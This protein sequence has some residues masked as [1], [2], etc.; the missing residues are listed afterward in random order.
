M[1]EKRAYFTAAVTGLLLAPVFAVGPT[2]RPDAT[3]KGSTLSG[4]HVLGQADWRAQNGELTGTTKPGG[5]GGWLVQDRSYQ[6]VA[7][8]SSFRCTGECKTGVLLRA[9]K[10]TDGMKGIYV[11]L[12]GGDVASYRVTLDAQGR[13]LQRE[14]L[15]F[16]G[17]QNRIA[18]PADANAAPGRGAGAGRGGRG[19]FTLA[20]GVTLPITPPAPGLRANDWNTVE[21]FLDANIVRAFL[22]DSG[23]TAGGVA[24]DEAGRYGP[25][26]LYIGGSGEVRFKDVA[27]KD[28][29]VKSA[30]PEEVSSGFRMQRLN[31]HYYAWSQA[32]ADINRDGILDIVAG[33]YYYLGPDYT[34]AREI[35][36]ARTVNP[37]R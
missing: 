37:S 26:A 33:P 24:D 6:D 19:G 25:L 2:F 18:P 12:T 16:A 32:A 9:E 34:T 31:E 5:G 13:E 36:A 35:Y 14:K 20:A 3:F 8:F 7:F 22:N 21:I 15:R 28:L 23:E 10:T 11:A 29:G 1:F 4:W 17:G 30:P 27:Y